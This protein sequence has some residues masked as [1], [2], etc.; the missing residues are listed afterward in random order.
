M[1]ATKHVQKSIDFIESNLTNPILLSDIAKQAGYSEFHYSRI[2]KELINMSPM[3]YLRRRRISEAVFMKF[4]G[5]TLYDCAEKYDFS[6]ASTLARALK[7]EFKCNYRE[8]CD[9]VGAI[10]LQHRI[11]LKTNNIDWR[12]NK[13]NKNIWNN[14]SNN[15]SYGH[16]YPTALYSA[17]KAQG[18]DM[19]ITDVI[20]FSGFAFF[21]NAEKE[22]CPSSMSVFDF[23]KHLGFAVN[24]CG[25]EAERIMRFWHQQ[26]EKEMIRKYAVKQIKTA[27]LENKIPICWDAVIPEWCIVVEYDEDN[28]KFLC[29][30]GNMKNELSPEMLGQR[31]IE[32]LDVTIINSLKADNID[33]RFTNA[34]QFAVDIAQGKYN[35]DKNYK[36]GIESFNAW[37]NVLDK[38]AEGEL[39]NNDMHSQIYHLNMAYTSRYHAAIFIERYAKGNKDLLKISTIY[40]EIAFMLNQMIFIYN[41]A[42]AKDRR[43]KNTELKEMVKVVLGIMEKESS[44]TSML[45]S[46][47]NNH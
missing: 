3:T 19:D 30:Y 10:D 13:M 28:D 5:Y 37:A 18:Y 14:P 17:L 25:L 35:I 39:P 2:F 16:S 41:L 45:I 42:R 38:I 20:G 4:A 9:A 33:I 36:Q 32:I 26:D 15:L 6:S 27:L 1:T 40:E 43:I 34:L 8:F 23:D 12:Y 47:L 29:Q 21:I 31:E 22:L 11:E 24:N 46:Y 7:N 44:A